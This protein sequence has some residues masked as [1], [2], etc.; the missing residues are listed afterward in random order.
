MSYCLIH[1]HNAL[2]VLQYPTKMVFMS[3]L[4]LMRSTYFK[5]QYNETLPLTSCYGIT[6]VLNVQVKAV[7]CKISVEHVPEQDVPPVQEETAL[8]VHLY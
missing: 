6:H 5:N 3:K 2:F 8:C 4:V 7:F 1:N